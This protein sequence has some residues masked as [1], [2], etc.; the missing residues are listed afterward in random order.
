[1]NVVFG[2]RA[3]YSDEHF[4][5]RA[6]KHGNLQLRFK[7]WGFAAKGKCPVFADYCGGGSV[8]SKGW[9]NLNRALVSCTSP[10]QNSLS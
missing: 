3:E 4:S 10:V 5:A 2:K 9:G 8:I 6:Y 7:R 1:M